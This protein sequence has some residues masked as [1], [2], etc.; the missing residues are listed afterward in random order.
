LAGVSVQNYPLVIIGMETAPEFS[1]VYMG[2]KTT[3]DEPKC[4]R[5]MQSA[6]KHLVR[7]DPD[8][9]AII[10]ECTNMPP[11]ADTVR[12]ATGL[13]VFDSVTLVNYA[14]SVIAAGGY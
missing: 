2:G 3:L 7:K 10:L 12:Q 1:S 11:Y 6:A 4:R 9:G 8:V 13:P 14:Y 5:E